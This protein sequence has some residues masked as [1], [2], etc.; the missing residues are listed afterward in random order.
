M[1]RG[2][3]CI[4]DPHDARGNWDEPTL[5]MGVVGAC[6]HSSLLDGVILNQGQTSSCV[7]HGVARAIQLRLRYLGESAELPNVL[8]IYAK[9]RTL[10][11]VGVAA[12]IGTTITAAC[13]AVIEDGFARES[14]W[15]F[16]PSL[17]TSKP[18]WDVAQGAFDQRGML[19]HRV[20]GNCEEAIKAALLAGLGVAIGIDC[21]ESLQHFTG[22]GIWTGMSGPRLGGHCMAALD[23]D[24][25]GL[26]VVNSWG[27][28][29]GAGG[30][31]RI[32]WDYL[33]SEHLRSAWIID[34]VRGYSG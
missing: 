8:H 21:D 4:P 25:E 6:D 14:L 23:Y 17:V 32:A 33:A 34:F 9:A 10:A 28:D 11:G 26:R 29:W 13:E 2:L 5:S 27:P 12:D 7:G 31:G 15:P 24:N 19:A 18:P 16:S 22:D 3:G 1:V 20:T 30:L